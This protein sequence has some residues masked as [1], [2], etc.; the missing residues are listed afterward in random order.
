MVKSIVEVLFGKDESTRL[1][2]S[3]KLNQLQPKFPASYYGYTGSLT[4]LM[5]TE[6]VA[7]FVQQNKLTIGRKQNSKEKVGRKLRCLR[8]PLRISG[9]ARAPPGC[10]TATS[11]SEDDSKENEQEITSAQVTLKKSSNPQV[12]QTIEKPFSVTQTCTFW[13][14]YHD[15]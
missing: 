1:K 5:C 8:A 15:S 7:W 2:S 9:D 10:A 3:L 6:G 12:G 14:L 13:G 4:V 11:N